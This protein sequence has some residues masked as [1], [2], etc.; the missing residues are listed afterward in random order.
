MN[1]ND[2]GTAMRS[3]GVNPTETELQVL[4]READPNGDGAVDR[5][6]FIILAMRSGYSEEAQ[7][8]E[9]ET[10]C[11]LPAF[12]GG[13]GLLH[14]DEVR[15]VFKGLGGGIT[16]DEI[17]DFLKDANFDADGRIEFDDL[18]K[19]IKQKRREASTT[20][21]GNKNHANESNVPALASSKRGK[22]CDGRR[23]RRPPAWTLRKP[24][25]Q[26]RGI[27]GAGNSDDG[28]I[29]AGSSAGSGRNC[30]VVV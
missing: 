26:R 3:V 21:V 18:V 13:S 25:A 15:R 11:F 24:G 22:I 14:L 7:L 10:R 9:F 30:S 1:I 12:G 23:S 29:A 16:D 6:V 4:M 28:R 20:S 19:L 17:D 5:S 27:R 2:L 8:E